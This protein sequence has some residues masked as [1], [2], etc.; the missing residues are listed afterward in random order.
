MA[1]YRIF[2]KNNILNNICFPFTY[3]ND[4]NHYIK[5]YEEMNVDDKVIQ[6]KENSQHCIQITDE[7]NE[8]FFSYHYLGKT[9][10]NNFNIIP[11]QVWNNYYQE[12]NE[13]SVI[14]FLPMRLEENVNSLTYYIKSLE[15]N[16]CKLNAYIGNCFNYLFCSNSLQIINKKILVPYI[17]SYSYIL[18]ISEI[19]N[20]A[21]P[22]EK[23]KQIIFIEL[24]KYL[25]DENRNCKISVMLYTDKTKISVISVYKQYKFIKKNNINKID[26]Y[27]KRHFDY[28]GFNHRIIFEN[29]FRDISI[30]IKNKKH[31]LIILV[32]KNIYAFDFNSFD[33][34]V[35]IN[36]SPKKDSI[37]SINLNYIIFIQII[38][39]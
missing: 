8:L 28:S 31:L 10:E 14:G 38:I 22:T 24:D 35:N 3:N 19:N 7:L 12:I 34:I 25:T 6:E 20:I 33:D 16:K 15:P 1:L 23:N 30:D 37:Y 4:K 9:H 29:I 36:I 18:N 32:Y 27:L 13:K 2:L 11:L 5:Y 39:K 21:P 17:D 26:L